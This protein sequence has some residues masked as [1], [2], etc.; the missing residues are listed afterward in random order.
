[1]DSPAGGLPESTGRILA[2]MVGWQ[3]KDDEWGHVGNLLATLDVAFQYSDVTA[4]RRAVIGLV[5][6]SNLRV[7]REISPT[8]SEPGQGPIPDA[9]RDVRDKLLHRIGYDE[10]TDR[11]GGDGRDGRDPESPNEVE[12][13]RAGP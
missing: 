4:A 2:S 3:L 5:R 7:K 9:I 13:R 1:M 6:W 12:G 10:R 8:I 11:D